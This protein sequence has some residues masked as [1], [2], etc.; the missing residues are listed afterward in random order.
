MRC[1]RAGDGTALVAGANG[2]GLVCVSR[3]LRAAAQQLRAHFTAPMSG[4]R[5]A[6]SVSAAL[7]NAQG[8]TTG[9]SLVILSI[10]VRREL[11]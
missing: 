3:Q 5:A 10:L 4:C 11:A 1:I 7:A 8:A 2:A 9:L 6:D